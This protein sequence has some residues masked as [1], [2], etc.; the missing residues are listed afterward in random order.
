M[1]PIILRSR[2]LNSGKAVAACSCGSKPVEVFAEK[3]PPRAFG[4]TLPEGATS[5]RTIFP[6]L[7]KG[8]WL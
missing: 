4:S 7:P 6:T 5:I 1:T 2:V 8:G 3:N